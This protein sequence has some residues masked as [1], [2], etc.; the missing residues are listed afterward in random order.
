MKMHGCATP[1]APGP[2]CPPSP[3]PSSHQKV[4]EPLTKQQLC[5]GRVSPGVGGWEAAH[6]FQHWWG[7]GGRLSSSWERGLC[8]LPQPAASGPGGPLPSYTEDQA[9]ISRPEHLWQ[10]PGKN[11]T[12]KGQLAP[13]NAPAD[14][15]AL[16][17]PRVLGIH[18][19]CVHLAPVAFHK[20]LAQVQP[21]LVSSLDLKQKTQNKTFHY[22][23]VSD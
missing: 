18:P 5:S 22:R 16:G 20:G 3:R 4:Q 1:K 12:F 8:S 21:S 13:H 2:A 10:K 6:G 19:S 23:I 14:C 15:F 11:L 7:L 9:F 17:S